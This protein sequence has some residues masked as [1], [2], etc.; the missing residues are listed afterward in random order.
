MGRVFGLDVSKHVAEVAVLEEGALERHRFPARVGA[1]RAFAQ[2]LRPDDRVAFESCT[3]AVAFHRLLCQHAGHRFAAGLGQQRE[4]EQPGHLGIGGQDPVQQADE[5]DRD[6]LARLIR[7]PI[8]ISGTRYAFAISAV[9][10]PATAR[11]VSATWLAR[12]SAG[13]QH[14][15][16]SVSVSS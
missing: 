6:C 5:P 11:R 12:E 3:N 13:W 9:V 1:I 14:R 2:Q 16:S 7:W 4:G 10:M 15:K 8:V